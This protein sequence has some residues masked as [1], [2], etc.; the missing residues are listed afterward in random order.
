MPH[1]P[2]SILC[3]ASFFKGEAF[4]QQAK[5]EGCTV[6]LLTSSQ[7]QQAD[8]PHESIDE[9]FFVNDINGEKG[10][11]NMR[12]VK[13]GLAYIMRSRYIDKIVSLDDFDVEK[14]A[15]LREHF[16]IPGMG[17]TTSRYFRDKLAMRVKALEENI[18]VPAFISLF[19]DEV[20]NNYFET[21]SA[22]WLI[23]PRGEASATG[24]KKLHNAHDAWATIHSLG[25]NRHQ[26]LIEQFRPGDVFHADSINAGGKVV[27]CSVSKYLSTPMEVAHGGGVFRSMLI[28]RNSPDE[29]AIQKINYEVMKAFGMN[30]SASHTEF[31]KD[32]ATGEF[33]F[34]E[35]SSRVGGANL[36][37]MIEAGT[38]VNMWREWARL[39]AA[40]AVGKKYMPPAAIDLYAGIVVSLSR[41]ECPDTASFT[42]TEIVWRMNKNHHIGL[43]VKADAPEKVKSFLDDYTQRIIKDF[44][45]A[46]DAP[47]KS[48]S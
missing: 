44:H 18:K 32:H 12:D 3:I 34:L 5:L 28:E 6:Y 23:K 1:R 41:F 43:I 29:M 20:I 10:N 14:G 30:Y 45:A 9:I 17:V 47:N 7:L 27:F 21:V 4:M 24:I 13:N 35:T 22:P 46:M 39:E 16:R 8:W 38:G 33:V 25:D 37:E 31:I 42:D 40:M 36:A 19:N 15:E 11:W 2:V 48:S 26:Y